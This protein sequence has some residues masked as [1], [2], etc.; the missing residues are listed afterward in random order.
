MAMSTR[1]SLTARATS[2]YGLAR[3]IGLGLAFAPLVVN[4]SAG[5]A[6]SRPR[7]ARTPTVVSTPERRWSL[8]HRVIAQDQ[9]D[10]QVDYRLRLDSG[11]AA[12]L[13]A[14]DLA[15]T[16]DGWVSNS[17]VP[18]HAVPRRS[19]PKV[20]GAAGGTSAH[21]VIASPDEAKQCR[22]RL[23][24]RAWSAAA[25]EPPPRPKNAPPNAP[26]PLAAVEIAP[27]GVL[28]V[29]H[30]A[31][32][33]TLPL[34]PVRPAPRA[35]ARSSSGSARRP[36]AT[37]CP[38]DREHYIAQAKATWPE[39]PEDR[40]DTRHFISGPDSLH[41]EA[42]I[43][44]NQYYRFPDRPVRVRDADEAQL[45]VPDRPR[46]RGR[47]PRQGLAVQ[48]G[49]QRVPDPPG[50]APRTSATASIGRWT[51]VERIVRTEPEATSVAL[52]F[53][54]CN[55]ADIGEVWIDDVKLEPAAPGAGGP[56][57]VGKN[58]G[59]VARRSTFATKAQ[60]RRAMSPADG[61]GRL[62]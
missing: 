35:T 50:R 5:P 4:L 45:L 6:P 3:A 62:A 59:E 8:V 16:V 24:L 31:R 58:P 19:T 22:E 15:A 12:A 32:A 9:G 14:G 26:D 51:K 47:V 40:R 20:D 23:V 41:L 57:S 60:R 1:R 44:G 61:R 53:K 29:R 33:R 48:G 36:S 37:P 46:R 30:P 42:H 2:A 11:P 55:N 34:R 21:E 38:L 27:G 13:A 54:I 43:N 49:P 25:A 39:P 52:D 7:P 17:R 28:C 10:W 56:L 18:S